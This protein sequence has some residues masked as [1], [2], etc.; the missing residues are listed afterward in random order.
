MRRVIIANLAGLALL[1]G[2]GGETSAKDLGAFPAVTRTAEPVSPLTAV[3]LVTVADLE[4]DPGIR[5]NR[6]ESL[7][8]RLDATE[9]ASSLSF[10][11]RM[12]QHE[13]GMVTHPRVTATA[14][15]EFRVDGVKLHMAGLW[16]L[17]LTVHIA[18]ADQKVV[19]PVLM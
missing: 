17:L 15:N 9:L 18:G 10:D 6:V 19:I 7:T 3:R 11:A 16:E 2:W 14:P 5:L 4:N 13:H 8:V 12:P 1:A